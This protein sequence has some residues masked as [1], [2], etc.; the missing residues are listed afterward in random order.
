[1]ILSPGIFRGIFAALFAVLVIGCAPDPPDRP[2]VLEPVTV[3]TSTSVAPTTSSSVPETT[4]REDPPPPVVVTIAP[5]STTIEAE[6]TIGGGRSLGVFS[7]T[8]YALRGTTATGSEAGPGSIAVDPSVIPLGT[9]LDVEGYGRGR[10]V[11][12]GGAIRGRRIDVWKSSEAAC[13]EWGR[14]PVEVLVV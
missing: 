8:C 9:E 10:A 3:T 11:D 4:V 5:T 7:A 12:T 2:R 14:R 13:V 6:V 1:M